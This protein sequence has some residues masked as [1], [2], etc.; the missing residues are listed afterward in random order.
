MFQT[1]E[2]SSRVWINGVPAHL[3]LSVTAMGKPGGQ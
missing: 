1:V 3:V 2:F